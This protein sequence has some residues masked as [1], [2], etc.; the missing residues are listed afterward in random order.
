MFSPAFRSSGRAMIED[1]GVLDL[2]VDL[3]TITSHKISF[4]KLK[5]WLEIPAQVKCIASNRH[6]F[7]AGCIMSIAWKRRSR[8][9]VPIFCGEQAFSKTVFESPFVSPNYFSPNSDSL[10]AVRPAEYKV[11]P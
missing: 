8:G 1:E 9:D 6:Q 3:V 4:N 10:A 5:A 11:Y 2:T 7:S